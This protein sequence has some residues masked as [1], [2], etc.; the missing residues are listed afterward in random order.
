MPKWNGL[1]TIQPRHLTNSYKTE[2]R[3]FMNKAVFLLFTF[4]LSLTTFADSNTAN[5]M[6][7]IPNDR[8]LNQLIIPGTHDSGTDSITSSSYFSISDPGPLPAWLEEISNILPAS[9][10]R[11]IV[12]G[13]S[14]T[15]PY[16]ISDQLNNGIRYFDFRVCYAKSDFYLCHTMLGDLVS[17]AL[18]NIQTFAQ[19]HPSEIIIVDFNHFYGITDSTIETAFLTTLKNNLGDLAV[20]NTY[21][22]K[23]TMGQIR[24]SKRQIIILMD[25]NQPISTPDLQQFAATYLWHERR[26][27]SPWPNASNITDLK[28]DLDTEEAY[29]A[30]TVST[31]T[32]LFVLQAIQT[33]NTSQVIDGIIAPSTYP[34]NIE[35]YEA[36]LN[37]V[38]GNWLNNYIAAD[39]KTAINIVIQ[40]WFTNQSELVPIAMQYDSEVAQHQ[41]INTDAAKLTQLKKWYGMR[42]DHT[43]RK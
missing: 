18:K 39:G 9:I 2:R 32:N 33:E 3:Y 41:K 16:S 8:T 19:A 22:S 20:S 38:L 17:D 37:Q 42:N 12:A 25:T 7:Q 23:S 34:N 5:W 29:R 13:W 30:K 27:N 35:N 28:N 1:P 43:Q 6:S 40:D 14:K 15:Q 10:I 11:P 26:I 21:H 31:A 24:Q 36:P 4:F